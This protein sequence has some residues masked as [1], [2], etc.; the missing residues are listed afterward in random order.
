MLELLSAFFIIVGLTSLAV[1]FYF[2]IHIKNILKTINI[3]LRLKSNDKQDLKEYIQSISTSLKEIGVL[4]IY[5]YLEYDYTTLLYQKDE[6]NSKLT[7]KK[8]LDEPILKGY[9]ELEVKLN[10]GEQKI[11]NSLIL[12]IVAMQIT[13]EVYLKINI[14]DESFRKIAKLQ[15]YIVHDLK[16]ILQFFSAFEYN[17][18]N[19]KSQKDKDEFLSYMKNTTK[20]INKKLNSIVA[21]LKTNQIKSFIKTPIKLRDF[22]EELLKLYKLNYTIQG[23]AMI[24]VDIDILQSAIENILSNIH[25]KSML[26]TSITTTITINRLE[27]SRIEV[28]ISDS[29][30]PFVDELLVCEAFYTTKNDGLGIGMY[31]SAA[32]LRELGATIECKNIDSKPHTIITFDVV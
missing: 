21:L 14:A 18:E 29:G 13:N 5:Y 1:V 12:H 8:V 26:D 11:L 10:K 31:Q 4:D 9:I 30:E 2:T 19:L 22:F 6:K 20:P 17:L 24:Y 23:D 3:L 16:N 28:D 7:V 27:D 15:T 32:M 25:Q